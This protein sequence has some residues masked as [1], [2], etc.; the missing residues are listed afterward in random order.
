MTVQYEEKIIQ[1]FAQNLYASAS[2]ITVALTFLGCI[3][4]AVICAYINKQLAGAGLVFGALTGFIY[5]RSKGFEYKLKAQLALC[6]LQI[7]KNSRP[8]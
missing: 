5:G 3:I 4:G 7:E 8:E 1:E 2:R 6:Q